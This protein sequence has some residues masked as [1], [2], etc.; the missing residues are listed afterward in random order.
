MCGTEE[1]KYNNR[2]N[3]ERPPW[4][5]TP[6]NSPAGITTPA[7]GACDA[8]LNRNS[9]VSVTPCKKHLCM[10]SVLLTGKSSTAFSSRAAQWV[11]FYRWLKRSLLLFRW[12][13]GE[14]EFSSATT[15]CVCPC[16]TEAADPQMQGST[17]KTAT[18]ARVAQLHPSLPLVPRSLYPI[19]Y[20]YLSNFL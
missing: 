12:A 1:L 11:Y 6:H 13:G 5:D 20:S 17:S 18:G 4:T 2:S 19:G 9:L 10:Q 3:S 15:F 7:P 8:I 14:L 16:R